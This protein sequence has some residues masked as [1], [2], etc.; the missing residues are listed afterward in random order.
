MFEITKNPYLHEEILTLSVILLFFI[1]RTIF[2][3]LITKFAKINEVLENRTNLIIKY[4]NILLGLL[5]ILTIIIIW[6][7]F[8]ENSFSE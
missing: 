1:L 2:N 5:C 6:S 8:K 4:I 3:K 7:S